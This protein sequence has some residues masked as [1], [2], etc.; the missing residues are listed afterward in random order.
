MKTKMINV[1]GLGLILLEKSSRA[2][3]LN[4]SVKPPAKI[5]VAVPMGV[6]Y[7]KAEMF[8]RSKTDWINNN[9]IKISTLMKKHGQ[10][11]LIDREHARRYLTKRIH[12]LA[13]QH[14]FI[15][16]N[17][18]IKNQKTRWGSCSS[19]NNINLNIK[20]LHLPR[21]LSDYVIMHELVH[22]KVKSHA[23][24]FWKML[25]K[26]VGDAKEYNENLKQYGLLLF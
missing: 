18:Y 3:Y 10:L 26:Y 15:Y 25:D 2:K 11:K 6:S 21:E 20:L 24:E 16:N 13:L 17:L 19:K 5:R 22:T 7:E 12:E 14:G 23:F 9:L 8:A 4:I 1:H